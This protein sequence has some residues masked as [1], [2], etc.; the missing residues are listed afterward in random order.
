ML[1]LGVHYNEGFHFFKAE[2]LMGF[3]A[4]WEVYERGECGRSTKFE[5]KKATLAGNTL[6]T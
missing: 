5:Q 4:Y 1:V 2:V 6:I 3:M